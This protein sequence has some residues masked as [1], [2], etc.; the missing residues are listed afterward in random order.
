[1]ESALAIT[2]KDIA[3]AIAGPDGDL[4][5]AIERIHHWT[6]EGL[7][8]PLGEKNPGTGRKRLYDEDAIIAARIFNVLAEYGVSLAT[9]H[10]VA[11]HGVYMGKRI[12]ADKAEGRECFLVIYK[13]ANIP[14]RA[15][16]V[17]QQKDPGITVL[18]TKVPSGS[19][20][21]MHGSEAALC[22]NLTKLLS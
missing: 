16:L 15:K 4:K 5:P 22:I 11:E 10:R 13:R 8:V 1:L 12:E 2:A 7:L 19:S 20:P 17:R 14:L 18:F 9:M 21:G 3:Q 6:N